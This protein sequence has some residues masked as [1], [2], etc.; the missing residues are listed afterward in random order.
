MY[1]AKEDTFAC[2]PVGNAGDLSV[3]LFRWWACTFAITVVIKSKS[4]TLQNYTYFADTMTQNLAIG[5][6]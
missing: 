3:C 5:E 1:F 6:P 4:M 2:Y